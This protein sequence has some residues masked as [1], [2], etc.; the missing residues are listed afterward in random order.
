MAEILITDTVCLN[1]WYFL[2]IFINFMHFTGKI[3]L[4]TTFNKG[5]GDII[6]Q[7]YEI[8]IYKNSKQNAT[9]LLLMTL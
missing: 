3:S 1:E 7:K 5:D 9:T 4:L 2:N 8:I 6:E